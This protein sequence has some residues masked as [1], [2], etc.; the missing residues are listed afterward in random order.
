MKNIGITAFARRQLNVAQES[1]MGG[2]TGQGGPLLDILGSYPEEEAKP[3]FAPFVLIVE[4]HKEDLKWFLG[5]FRKA[6]AGEGITVRMEARREGENPV[7]VQYL[8]GQKEAPEAAR[9]ILY[10]REQLEKEGAAEGLD[11][12]VEWAVVS[13]NMGPADE[14]VAPWTMLRNWAASRHPDAPDAKGGSPHYKDVSDE[15][16]I[17]LLAQSMLYWADRGRV[18]PSL[19]PEA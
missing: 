18:V 13:I 17:K 8:V 9:V 15:E 16:F 12:W 6:H 4:I 14:P 2:F 7:P 5:T 19:P 10:S 11:G 1:A 3:G